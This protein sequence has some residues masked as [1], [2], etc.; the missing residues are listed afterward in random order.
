MDYHRIN[1]TEAVV[2]EIGEVV[3]IVGEEKN[4]G[5]W[6]KEKVLQHVTERD[7]VIRGGVVLHKGECTLT[8]V[9]PTGNHK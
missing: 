2:P 4:R 6:M 9:M 8:A 3:L 7:G 1:R 5:L